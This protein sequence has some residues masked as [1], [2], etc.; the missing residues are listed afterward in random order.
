M[1]FYRAL[2]RLYPASFR[3]EYGDEMTQAFADRRRDAG[4]PAARLAIAAGAIPEVLANAL[5]V[6]RDVLAQ[7]L[8][9][10]ARTLN[11]AR[12]FALTAVLLVALGVGANAAAFSIVDFLLFRQLPFPGADSLVMIWQQ[13]PG[14]G[15]MELAPANFDDWRRSSVSFESSGAYTPAPATL[16]TTGEPTRVQG[17]L[18]TADLLATLGVRPALGR[19]FREG[20]DREGA[21]GLLILSDSL[22]RAAFGGDPG[23]IG[24][25]V[26]VNDEM[27]TIVGVMPPGFSFP[28]AGEQF[29][30]PLRISAD[31]YR[32]RT[33]NFLYGIARLKPGVT[34]AA[35][36]AELSAR[37]AATRR[38]FP[39]ENE[40]TDALV[41]DFHAELVGDA[42]LMVLAFTGAALCLLLIVCANLGNLLIARALGRQQELAIR[43]AMGAGRERLIRQLA[44]ESVALAIA[45][46]VAGVGVAAALVPA[47]WAMI[48]ARLPTAVEPHV[49]PRVLLFAM[50]LTLATALVFGLAPMARSGAHPGT[51]ALREGARAIG[52]RRARLR[53]ALVAAEVVGSVILLVITGLLLRA[54]WTLQQRDPGF[55]ADGVLT[56]QTDLP[57]ARFGETERRA[58][59]YAQILDQVRALPGVTGAAWISGLPMVWGGG[60]WPVGI[61]GVELE[62]RESNAASLRFT[63]PGFFATLQIPVL[64]GR[65]VSDADTNTTQMVAVVSESLVSRYW[66]GQD[67][68]GRRF[69]FA[70]RERTIVGIVADIRVRGLERTSEPQV[71]LPHRQMPDRSLLFYAPKSLVVRASTALA[72]VAPAVRDIVRKADPQVPVFAVRP[73]TAI[74]ERTT[75]AR[76]LQAGLLGG[77]A[78]VAF[79]LA[80]IGIHGVLAFTVSQRTAEIGVRM[81]LGAQR[82][83][84]LGMVVRHGAML[85]VAGLLPGVALAYA[86][87]RGLE[88]MLVG[89]TPGD[90][91]AFGAA[92]GL[93]AVMAAIG[94]LLPA[95]RAVRID[96]VVAIRSQQS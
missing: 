91:L 61:N 55:K 67:A 19:L 24:R 33:D 41:A 80:A 45:G 56:L 31:S 8:R 43:T 90:P 96:P 22:W 5:A 79:L 3:H 16:S 60:I 21:P 6:H 27:H 62:R 94:M 2:L 7:D 23:A 63:T 12:G 48:P 15:R 20:E 26:R 44:T 30:R 84:I 70:G 50:L 18:V 88:S 36:Q 76:R 87:A 57:A 66:P 11:R 17:A 4:S 46:G 53:G 34:L 81:A 71:Y 54:L 78:A 13:Q 68:I 72:P 74:V 47:L 64:A 14:Y 75:G 92:V 42:R 77:F 40:N 32:D 59:L 73:L 89:I 39:K 49:D 93:T 86:A 51:E 38:D 52:G 25:A 82:R 28:S 65:D 35:A 58:A 10:T 29:W 85:T 95:W 83:D 9:Y 37:A 1:R 69:H